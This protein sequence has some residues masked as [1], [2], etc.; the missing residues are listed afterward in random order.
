MCHDMRAQAK[1]TQ[2]VRRAP[3]LRRDARRGDL[4]KRYA[5]GIKQMSYRQS[6]FQVKECPGELFALAQC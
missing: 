2:C 4:Y 5:Y 1:L 6:L 3:C